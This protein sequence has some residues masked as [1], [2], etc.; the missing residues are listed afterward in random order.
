MEQ[1]D[2]N[3]DGAVSLEEFKDW[4]VAGHNHSVLGD[5]VGMMEDLTA[6]PILIFYL[7]DEIP[8]VRHPGRAWNPAALCVRQPGLSISCSW[9]GPPRPSWRPFRG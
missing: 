9:C 2:P 8:V 3:G 5:S 7:F 1:L 4:W 6:A